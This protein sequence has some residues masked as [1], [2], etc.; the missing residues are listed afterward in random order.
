VGT[1]TD[2]SI[3][4]DGGRHWIER[5]WYR[6]DFVSRLLAPLGWFYCLLV[7]LRRQAYRWRLLSTVRLPVPVIVVGNITVGGTGK[8][9]LVVW[10]AHFLRRDGYH[11]GIVARGYGG[12]ANDW[13]KW[14]EATSDP[15]EVGDEPVLLAR[16]SRCPVAAGPDRV[17][18]ARLLLANH[19]CDVILSDD[20]LQHYRLARDLEIAVI[21]GER[22]FGN[23]RCLPA[24][25]L[26]EPITRLH[27]VDARVTQGEPAAGEWGMTLM[28][29][30]F[31]SLVS[32][33]KTVAIEAFRGKPVH[34][35]A[36]IGYPQRFFALLRRC[37]LDPIEHPFP[38][39]HPYRAEDIRFDDD[40]D[41]I[42]TEKDA[43]KCERFANVH[44]WYLDVTVNPDP[45]M[46]ESVRKKLR[47]LSYG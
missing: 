7:W 31:H 5:H 1:I 20:G 26:R 41:V 6:N 29:D 21:D 12:R 14:V 25:P 36:G 37:G 30:V 27:E 38:D 40:Y 2:S 4:S 15:Q 45:H 47:E 22:R 10:L 28:P 8:T 46:G 16:R 42:M 34:A 32:P 3:R 19:R 17:R 9:P 11:P 33:E 43:I 39:H 13:P 44:G 18:A 23:G 24:G 35:V